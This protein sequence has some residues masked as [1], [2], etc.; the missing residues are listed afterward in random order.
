MLCFVEVGVVRV[1]SEKGL[2]GVGVEPVGVGVGWNWSW[3]GEIT[4][5]ITPKTTLFSKYHLGFGLELLKLL[6]YV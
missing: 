3:V 6:G 2:A 5:I 1:G 4:S